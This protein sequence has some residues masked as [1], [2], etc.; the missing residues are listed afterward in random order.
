MKF[1]RWTSIRKKIIFIIMLTSGITLLSA[2]LLYLFYD[3]LKTRQEIRTE[4]A[5]LAEIIGNNTVAALMFNDE[6]AAQKTLMTLQDQPHIFAAYI[7]TTDNRI[8]AQYI[9]K[10]ADR[11]RLKIRPKADSYIA[12]ETIARLQEES[13]LYWDPDLDLEV[14]KKITLDNQD[15][16]L[17]VI[18][19]YALEKILAKMKWFIFL[20]LIAMA[21]AFGVAYIISSRL[22]GHIA[23][24]ILHLSEIMKEVSN[25][26][27]YS[28]RAVRESDDE[29]GMLYD[30]FNQMLSDIQQRDRKLEEYY[31]HLEEYHRQL[32]AEIVQRTRASDEW[33]A[34]FDATREIIIMLDGDFAV[35]KANRASADFFGKPYGEIMRRPIDELLQEAGFSQEMMP[36]SLMQKTKQ[37]EEKEIYWPERGKWLILSVDPVRDSGN[38]L[39]EAVFIIRD[40]TNVKKAEDEQ[41][42]LQ[43]QLLQI[44][45]MDS[46]GRLAGG[47]AHDFNNILSSILGYGELAM[48]KLADGDPTKEKLKIIQSSGEK[49]AALTRQLLL[50][51]RK[52]AAEMKVVD[53]ASVIDG[54]TKMLVRLIGENINLNVKVHSPLNHISCDAGQIEQVIMNLVVNARDA[55]PSGGTL[56]IIVENAFLHEDQF[57]NTKAGNYVLMAVSDSG[58]GMSREVQ[59]K[60]FEPFFTTKPV[61]KGTGLGLSTTYGIVQQHGGHIHVY[62]EIGKGTTFRI[63][64]P[65][66]EGE[67]A[68]NSENKSEIDTHGTETILIAEDDDQLR[69]LLRTILEECGYMI[70]EAV[71]GEEAVRIFHENRNTVQLILLDVIMP[72]KNGKEAYNEI[73]KIQPEIKTLFMSGYTADIVSPYGILEEGIDLIQKPISRTELLT[74]MRVILNT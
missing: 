54:T 46:I 1:L 47:I 73:K 41:R 4:L 17:V 19:A 9:A 32:E 28:I 29:V 52:Q 48:M 61:G 26:Q 37:H 2:S 25:K 11:E 65:V 23:D 45:K 71:D 38:E 72:K 13:R 64:F 62:S 51:S 14:V 3:A 7:I 56:E 42:K 31:R 60:I 35:V 34:T 50:F 12:P 70:I 27:T 20:T 21:V 39:N 30:G 57:L 40:T 15:M 44:Q 68:H 74:K 69:K 55:M 24:P 49:A 43:A 59:E 16:G 66:I 6:K 33:R 8:L 36:L 18:Q 22:Q 53:L 5:S 67:I 63:Y 58:E 10:T